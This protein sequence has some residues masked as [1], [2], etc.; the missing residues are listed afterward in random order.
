MTKMNPKK[1]IN[2]SVQ[3]QDSCL[4]NFTFISARHNRPQK[5]IHPSDNYFVIY[6]DIY[7]HV[8]SGEILI[9]IFTERRRC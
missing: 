4:L 7:I 5:D 2:Y 8:C 6:K 1:A 3:V 9:I